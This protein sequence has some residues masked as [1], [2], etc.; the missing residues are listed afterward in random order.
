[1]PFAFRAPTILIVNAPFF[2]GSGCRSGSAAATT[3]AK[4]NQPARVHTDCT[5]LFRIICILLFGGLVC[6]VPQA[7]ATAKGHARGRGAG[8]DLAAT[9]TGG[10]RADA[11]T[12]SASHSRG[13]SDAQRE[14][15]RPFHHTGHK[16]V[17]RRRD[18][19]RTTQGRHRWRAVW[20]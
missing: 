17:L 5:T 2:A 16:V 3:R 7:A 12:Y 6:V 18:C 8:H 4:P 1:L 11:G 20:P 9:T 13:G 15:E 14:I 19:R 10:V